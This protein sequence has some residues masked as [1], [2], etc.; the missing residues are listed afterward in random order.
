MNYSPMQSSKVSLASIY[1]ICVRLLLFVCVTVSP[2]NQLV[3]QIEQPKNVLHLL[4]F[5]MLNDLI[6][7]DWDSLLIGII[8]YYHNT[9]EAEQFVE[10]CFAC[11]RLEFRFR[12]RFDSFFVFV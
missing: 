12:F 3:V 5:I 10:V 11:R 2:L 9:T 6:S 4:E 1:L 8:G 7:D